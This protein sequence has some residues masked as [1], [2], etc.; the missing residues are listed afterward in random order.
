VPKAP[1]GETPKAPRGWS[2]GRGYPTIHQGGVW[3]GGSA[4]SPANVLN[5]GLKM[6]NFGAI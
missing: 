6:V 3:E 1:R 5:F 2:V 4:P